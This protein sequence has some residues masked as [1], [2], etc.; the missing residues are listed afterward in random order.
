ML[1]KCVCDCALTKDTQKME[2]KPRAL[3][4]RRLVS[5]K[6]EKNTVGTVRKQKYKKQFLVSSAGHLQKTKVLTALTLSDGMNV[7]TPL[8]VR[9]PDDAAGSFGHS[10]R[11]EVASD[12]NQRGEPQRRE[13]GRGLPLSVPRFGDKEREKG[14]SGL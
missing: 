2:Y 1:A 5:R 7:L 13:E 3:H 14:H 8:S 9:R 10:S 4:C 6:L 12:G 11:E